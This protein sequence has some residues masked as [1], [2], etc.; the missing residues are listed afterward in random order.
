MT[1]SNA[2]WPRGGSGRLTGRAGGAYRKDLNGDGEMNTNPF[3][4]PTE[5]YAFSNNA[6]GQFGP[7]SWADAVFTVGA[8]ETAQQIN[9]GG[10]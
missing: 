4:I 3:G 9:V 5:P 7:A 6:R 10:N 8:G 1:F 2:I